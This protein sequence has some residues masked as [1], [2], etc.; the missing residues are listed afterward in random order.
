MAGPGWLTL[1][2]WELREADACKQN[3]FKNDSACAVGVNG[4]RGGVV[5]RAEKFRRNRQRHI[6]RSRE[7]GD[8]EGGGGGGGEG[9]EKGRKA[10]GEAACLHA[11]NLLMVEGKQTIS[12]YLC[13]T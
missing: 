10:E 12:Y 6:Y 11:S 2:F 1:Q 7:R 4:M 5:Y 13:K 9:G 3:M 8:E